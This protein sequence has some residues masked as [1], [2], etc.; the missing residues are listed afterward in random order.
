MIAWVISLICVAPNNWWPFFFYLEENLRLSQT[1]LTHPH[2]VTTTMPFSL[3]GEPVPFSRSSS[4]RLS[5]SSIP[6]SLE[7]ADSQS[8]LQEF[9]QTPFHQ[10]N[11]RALVAWMDV[12]VGESLESLSLS[13]SP[14]SICF[15]LSHS[16]SLSLSLPLSFLP[17]VRILVFW[18][19]RVICN[20]VFVCMAC[21]DQRMSV[22]GSV[23]SFV[24][25]NPLMFSFSSFCS[26]QF[27]RPVVTQH[28]FQLPCCSFGA[29]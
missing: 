22:E 11:T 12:I 20:L 10:W 1:S 19:P 13:F 2:S 5:T 14:F 26:A 9:K 21:A 7:Q 3:P 16:L 27:G 28:L 18:V 4:Q 23:R 25:T 17:D 29:M 24:A 8:V 6:T 15:S